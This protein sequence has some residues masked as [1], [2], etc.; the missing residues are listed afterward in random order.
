MLIFKSLNQQVWVWHI[1]CTELDT[2]SQHQ[3]WKWTSWFPGDNFIGDRGETV[4]MFHSNYSKCNLKN[5]PIARVPDR[6]RFLSVT[7]RNLSRVSSITMDFSIIFS[8]QKST[9][10][11]SIW[12][13]KNKFQFQIQRVFFWPFRYI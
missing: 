13:W 4:M 7:V 3:S 2:I 12:M 1:F 9:S 6:Y 5:W 10:V 8:F 11:L